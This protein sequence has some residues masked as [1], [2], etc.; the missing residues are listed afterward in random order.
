[1]KNLLAWINVLLCMHT[2]NHKDITFSNKFT[3]SARNE[4]VVLCN[5]NNRKHNTL[6]EETRNKFGINRK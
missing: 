1:M 2:K 4:R 5:I 6:C 3:I